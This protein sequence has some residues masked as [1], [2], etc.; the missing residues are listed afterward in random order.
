MLP[1]KPRADGALLV[2]VI[3]CNFWFQ[4]CLNTEPQCPPNFCH[5][6]DISSSIQDCIYAGFWGAII[7][8]RFL[9]NE[10]KRSCNWSSRAKSTTCT[11]PPQHSKSLSEGLPIQGKLFYVA[12]PYNNSWVLINIIMPIETRVASEIYF[13]SLCVSL[14]TP[15]RGKKRGIR[16]VPLWCSYIL[17]FLWCGVF[18]S[19]TKSFCFGAFFPT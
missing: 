13:L 10:P 16:N 12:L 9:G 1:A 14:N 8:Y 6:K 17:Y 3:N 5:K 7:N 18:F 19:K 2:R 4:S 11:Q 15:H